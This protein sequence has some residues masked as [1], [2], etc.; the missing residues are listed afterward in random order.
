M[1]WTWLDKVQ[2]K[3]EKKAWQWRSQSKT[4][5]EGFYDEVCDGNAIPY[6]TVGIYWSWLMEPGTLWVLECRHTKP[7]HTHPGIKHFK[8]HTFTHTQWHTNI[9]KRTPTCP[10]PS[11]QVSLLSSS[12]STREVLFLGI[13]GFNFAKSYQN[14]TLEEA[15]SSWGDELSCWETSERSQEG[16]R[17]ACNMWDR[18]CDHL[19]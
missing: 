19:R 11:L 13:Y 17:S 2:C 9:H 1:T 10:P 4:E 15:Q 12:T 7:D 18:L 8:T 6:I 14:Y 5:L 16:D 3:K